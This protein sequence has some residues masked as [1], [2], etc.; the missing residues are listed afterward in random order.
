[1]STVVRGHHSGLCAAAV[2]VDITPSELTELNPVGGGSFTAVHDPIRLR[3]LL[4]ANGATQ[5]ALIA[6]DLIEV[7]DMTGVRQRVA[8][9]LGIPASHVVITASHDHNAPRLGEVSPG[10]LAHGGGP[11][12]RAYTAMVYERLIGAIG[13]ARQQLRPARLGFG[14]GAV[15]VNVNRDVRSGER[16]ELGLNPDGAS[17][18]TV[19]VIRVDGSDGQPIA[20]WFNYAVH[21]TVTLWTGLL[22]ADLAGAAERYVEATLGTV[23][24]FTPGALG[25]QA[26]RASFE[27]AT[28]QQR[29]D[30][31]Y[32]FRAAEQ[33]GEAL[34]AEVV[35]VFDLISD[36]SPD[37]PIHAAEAV[38]PCPVKRGEDVMASMKQ[39]DAT[40][41]ELRVSLVRLGDIALVGV[42]GEVVTAI[43]QALQEV[44]P[45]PRTVVVSLVND[46]VGYLVDDAAYALNTFE[47]RGC[48]VQPGHVE[49]R[50]VETFLELVSHGEGRGDQ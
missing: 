20:V 38:V 15:D 14:R 9:E 34:G 2:R 1:M 32:A 36:A 40:E 8:A 5:I 48:P 12:Q 35:R 4:L 3:C 47:S 16:Y 43:G 21:S 45:L 26:P 13:D 46:R 18:K 41:V 7:G 17:D 22:S 29:E 37:V 50:L 30:P 25:D 24:L 49:Q 28:P 27:N 23:A 33:L 10:A 11:A 42:N 19:S 44:S 6:V 31:H 39:D